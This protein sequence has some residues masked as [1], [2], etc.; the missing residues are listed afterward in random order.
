MIFAHE[1]LWGLPFSTLLSNPKVQTYLR[2]NVSSL[3]PMVMFDVSE[4]GVDPNKAILC[5][6]KMAINET[7]MY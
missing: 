4:N 2:R 5:D 1:K 7:A 6:R 3:E